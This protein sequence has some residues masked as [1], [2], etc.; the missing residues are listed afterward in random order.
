MSAASPAALPFLHK[1]NM[2]LIPMFGV[3][4]MYVLFLITR[5]NMTLLAAHWF[6]GA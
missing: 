4:V 1:T 5:V 3:L 2:M 6:I